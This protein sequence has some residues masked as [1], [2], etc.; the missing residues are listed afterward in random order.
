[1]KKPR[2]YVRSMSG[3]W[4]KNPYYVR[5]IIREATSVLV[6]AYAIVLLAAVASLAAGEEAYEGW[7]SA[8]ASP[9][10]VVFHL[11]ALAAVLYHMVTWFAVSPKA[12]PP[13][14]IGKDKLPDKLLIG[15]QYAATIALS[16]VIL[17][18]AWKL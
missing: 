12:M 7:L 15:G 18:V 5:Y 16:V 1:M 2:T 13:V 10:A 9:G 6:A 8:L 3:W 4:L 17:L 11:L 14:Y